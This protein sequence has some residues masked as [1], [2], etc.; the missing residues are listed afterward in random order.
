MSTQRR[1]ILKNLLLAIPDNGIVCASHLCKDGLSHDNLKQYVQHGYLDS[2]GRGAYCKHDQHPNLASALHALA[3]QLNRSFHL[4]GRTALSRQGLLHF[5][6]YSDEAATIYTRHNTRLPAWFKKFFN[7]QFLCRY[8]NF[9]PKDLA[10]ETKHLDSFDV[11]SS[12]PERAILEYLLD[13]PASH[14]LNEAYQIMEMMTNARPD[15]LQQLLESCSSIKVKR[16]FFLLAEDLNYAWY[17]DL[18]QDK[19]DLGS[20]CRIIDK[21]GTYQSQWNVVVKDWKEI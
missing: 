19:I 6:P 18:D 11:P 4:G 14:P 12:M 21:G 13:V 10:I 16:L 7:G 1:D 20:G 15:I 9:L 17:E 5:L 8:T 2:L 3:F